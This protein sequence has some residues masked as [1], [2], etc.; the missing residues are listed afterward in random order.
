MS[1]IPESIIIFHILFYQ[2][3]QLCASG[4]LLLSEILFHLSNVCSGIFSPPLKPHYQGPILFER[5][6]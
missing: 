5:D 1:L 2:G 3:P 6:N 4:L